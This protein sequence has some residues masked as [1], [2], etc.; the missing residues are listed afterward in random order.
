MH[1]IEW[2]RGKKKNYLMAVILEAEL[3]ISTICYRN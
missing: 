2:G 3:F 1:Y